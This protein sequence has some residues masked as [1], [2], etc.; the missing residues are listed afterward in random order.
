[1]S[2][3][4]I[5][6]LLHAAKEHKDQCSREISSLKQQLIQS[7]ARFQDRSQQSSNNNNSKFEDIEAK[8]DAYRQTIAE[9][10]SILAKVEA[11]YQLT[12]RYSR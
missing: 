11:D 1:M 8:E 5:T 7:E 4:R 10:D 3:F 6:E 12:I 2:F 9:A